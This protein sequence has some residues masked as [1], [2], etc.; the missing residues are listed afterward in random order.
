MKGGKKVHLQPDEEVPKPQ[1]VSN[2]RFILKM[3]FLAVV[4]HPR[5]LSNGVWFDREI[6]I[7]SIVDVV[8]T[9]GQQKL[10]QGRLCPQASHVDGEKYKETM[11][12]WS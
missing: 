4:A 8:G 10:C 3:M 11:M 5:K 2:K 12:M 9:A 1:R 6:S 7:W